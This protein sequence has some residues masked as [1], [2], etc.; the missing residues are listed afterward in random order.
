MGAQKTISPSLKIQLT[1]QLIEDSKQRDSSHCMIAEAV[2]AAF[3]DAAYV[4]VD[5]Q[6]IRF[7]DPG[8]HRRYT[9]LTPRVAQIALV[10]FDQGITPEPFS[11]TLRRGQ[12]T[13]AGAREGRVRREL[14]EAERQQRKDAASKTAI[15]AA[16][17]AKAK[18]KSQELIGTSQRLR[19]GGG[20][21]ADSGEIPEKIGGKTPPTTSFAR[22]RTFGL[23]ALD[24]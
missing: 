13:M 23:R 2:K 19:G 4:S 5:L 17:S 21:G 8:K 11:F 24:R 22:R 20:G 3:P 9:Y 15:G 1:T 14:S 10:D 12:V 6:T 7:S 16:K 18:L